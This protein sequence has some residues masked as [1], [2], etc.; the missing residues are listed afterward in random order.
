MGIP[1]R[2]KRPRTIRRYSRV[3]N[4]DHGACQTCGRPI[5]A[6]DEYEADVIVFKGRLWVHKT[7]KYCPDDLWEEEFRYLEELDAQIK[8]EETSDRSLAA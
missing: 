5:H 7:H 6:G 8:A 2:P 4:K 1:I 3:A